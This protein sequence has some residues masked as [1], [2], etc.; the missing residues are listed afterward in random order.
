MTLVQEEERPYSVLLSFAFLALSQLN[1]QLR[2]VLVDGL[3][4]PWP[5]VL[6]TD[7]GVGRLLEDFKAKS[8]IDVDGVGNE[9]LGYLD[10]GL[11]ESSWLLLQPVLWV[12][13]DVLEIGDVSVSS[14]FPGFKGLILQ[15]SIESESTDLKDG[16]GLSPSHTVFG[17]LEQNR[18]AAKELPQVRVEVLVSFSVV[19][20]LSLDDAALLELLLLL[21]KGDRLLLRFLLLLGDHHEVI[22]RLILLLLRPFVSLL[23]VV[24]SGFKLLLLSR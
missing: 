18:V 4:L 11:E 14:S 22:L 1:Q 9:H 3:E 24:E 2:H 12:L 16:I 15:G 5:H 10:S 6:A 20:L 8:D 21:I 19:I 7:L 17:L 13:L 23:V